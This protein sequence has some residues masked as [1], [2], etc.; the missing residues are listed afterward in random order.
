MSDGA[1]GIEWHGLEPYVA[2]M[3]AAPKIV[4][5]ELG[6]AAERCAALGVQRSRGYVHSVSGKLAGSIRAQPVAFAGGSVSVAW[7]TSLP[8][9]KFVEHGRGPIRARRGKAL[10]FS[11]GGTTLFRVSV[12]PAAPRPFISRAFKELRGRFRQEFRTAMLVIIQ[13]IGSGR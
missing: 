7:G 11:I 10:R 9:A 4:R 5:E 1:F 8:Y 12:G 2:R 13:R 3:D 6:H